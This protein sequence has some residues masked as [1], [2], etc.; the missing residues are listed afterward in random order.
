MRP[1]LGALLAGLWALT[2]TGN[3]FADVAPLCD[4]I[5]STRCCAEGVG[6][7]CS[8]GGKCVA[9]NCA[10]PGSSQGV[11][12]ACVTCPLV[13]DAGTNEAGAPLC[14]SMTD[15]GKECAGGT[16][17]CARAP[18]GCDTYY[19]CL[20]KTQEAPRPDGGAAVCSGDAGATTGAG[21]AAG[22]T[23]GPTTERVDAGS[24]NGGG[25]SSS[26]SDC[27]VSTTPG[28]EGTTT[29]TLLAAGAL[30]GAVVLAR[31]GRRPRDPR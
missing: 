19:A 25:G 6:K 23:R 9:L 13:L 4:S 24:G 14:S 31:R 8:S 11:V 28:G 15:Y 26:S 29:G 20:H 21:T 5:T 27:G 30:V 7:A 18:Q 10:G 16:G 3:A 17:T 12:H 22:T 1:Y 2:V